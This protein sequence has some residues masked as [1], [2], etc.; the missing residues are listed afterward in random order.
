MS[1]KSFVDYYRKCWP[2]ARRACFPHFRSNSC[3]N[4][5]K[6]LHNADFRFE[7]CLHKE[8]TAD[9]KINKER[10]H[11]DAWPA[12]KT[13]PVASLA[14]HTRHGRGNNLQS[15]DK[16]MFHTEGVTSLTDRGGDLAS[17]SSIWVAQNILQIVTKLLCWIYSFIRQQTTDSICNLMEGLWCSK[18]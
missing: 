2:S 8:T 13:R 16:S 3:P 11:K 4:L 18:L 9:S 14:I 1:H 6:Q 12:W 10:T 15:G 5:D 17:A 7:I